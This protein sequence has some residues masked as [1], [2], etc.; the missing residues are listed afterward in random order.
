MCRLAYVDESKNLKGVVFPVKTCPIE[1]KDIISPSSIPKF[2]I[3]YYER[4]D[5]VICDES[6]EN[7]PYLESDKKY[8]L[9]RRW[10]EIIQRKINEI[11]EDQKLMKKLGLSIM[12]EEYVEFKD[13]YPMNELILEFYSE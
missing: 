7:C 12:K 11:I 13:K 9:E 6:I 10:N 3:E 4:R 5:Y 1:G 8:I 2:M